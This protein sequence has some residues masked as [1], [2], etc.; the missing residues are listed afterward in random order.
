V[1]VGTIVYGSAPTYRATALTAF[2][3]GKTWRTV[4]GL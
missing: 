2:W 4:S 3:N 1:A